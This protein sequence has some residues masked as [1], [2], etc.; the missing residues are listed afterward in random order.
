MKFAMNGALIIG[1]MVR[2]GGAWFQ[3]FVGLHC[4]GG[5]P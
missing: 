1:T 3:G 5:P 4:S 2:G